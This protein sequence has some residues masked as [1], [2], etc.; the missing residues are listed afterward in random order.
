LEAF[1]YSVSH[2]LRAPLRAIDGFSKML[3]DEYASKLDD[4]GRG[5]IQR[6]GDS[7]RRMTLLIDDLLKLSRLTRSQVRRLPIDLSS[8]A[9][10]IASDLLSSQ[11]ERQAKF[12]IEPGLMADADPN[13][14]RIVLEN[15][16][17]NA[18]KFTS[19]RPVAHIEFGV[20]IQDGGKVFFVRD[21]GAGF[22][23]DYAGKLF[24]AFQR[25]H[26]EQEYPGTGIGLATVQRIIYR[27]GGRVWAEGAVNAGAT[28]YFTL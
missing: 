9:R 5:Y 7:I 19:K 21:N 25:L 23:M 2:D 12:V 20:V 11:S 8:L 1:S 10:S 4:V 24:G 13:L 14:M 17:N 22:D 15:L 28:F 6:V 18:W 3:L 26:S 27:H 16:I